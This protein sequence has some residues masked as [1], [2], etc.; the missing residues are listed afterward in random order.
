MSG[1]ERIPSPWRLPL[2]LLAVLCLM[3]LALYWSTASAMAAIWWRSETY[4]H[5]MVVPLVSLWLVWRARQRVSALIP[6]PAASAWLLMLGAAG[7]WLVGDLVS[8]NSATQL[9][10]V[11][12]LVLA[13]PAVLGW[14]VA[15]ALA[16]PLGFLFL[17][18]PV[19]DFMLPKMMEWTADF[20]VA[21]LRL[22]GIPV[23]RE[24]QQFVIPSGHWSV[25]E[26]CSGIRYLIASVTVGCLFAYLS[27]NSWRKR[28]LFMLVAIATPLLANWLRAYLVVMLGHLSGN[29]LATGVDHL[30]YGWLFFGVVILLMLWVGGRWADAPRPADS[31]CEPCS[32]HGEQPRSA[33]LP[34]AS[35][36]L[37]TALVALTPHG[38]E[39]QFQ[40]NISTDPVRLEVPASQAPWN[41]KPAPST[42]VPA[43]QQPSASIHIGYGSNDGATVG[44]H[45]AY[46]R[47]QD[48]ERKLVSSENVLVRSEDPDWVLVSDGTDVAELQQQAL[49]V[50]SSVLRTAGVGISAK[51]RRLLVWQFFW[52]NGHLTASPVR[53][54][55]LG[56]LE[57]AQ[58]HGDDGAIV[59]VYTP[60]PDNSAGI[61]DREAAA[62]VLREFLRVQGNALLKSL[63]Q[64]RGG[65]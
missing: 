55:L 21:A 51:G 45:M 60:V 20:T 63:E 49:T 44:V 52:V 9:A 18:V 64:T 14:G 4:A 48:Y 41:L 22:S 58:G 32:A 10:L 42:W 15:R 33:A 39:W 5:G 65:R 6:R 46:Y 17:A 31:A 13:V 2:A 11:S 43:F 61:P 12:M 8:V 57:L 29:R 24:G 40:R 27:Y 35:S 62:R 3:I 34:F 37:V 53:A 25:V 56:A 28:L 19:G 36:A 59:A 23:Y 50:S 54:K 26:A 7:L 1:Q 47:Q 30:V 38:L 16:F